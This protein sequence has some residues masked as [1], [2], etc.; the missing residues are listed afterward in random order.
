MDFRG[1][2]ISLLLQIE[3][4]RREGRGEDGG[5]VSFL[6]IREMYQGES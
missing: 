2:E 6:S 4:F 5:P 3:D 1:Q